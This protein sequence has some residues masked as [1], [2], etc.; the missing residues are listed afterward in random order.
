MCEAKRGEQKKRKKKIRESRGEL[1]EGWN[2]YA[3]AVREF[4][5]G[6]DISTLLSLV[7]EHKKYRENFIFLFPEKKL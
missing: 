2:L 4:Y 5:I 3:R 1:K 7:S 6:E